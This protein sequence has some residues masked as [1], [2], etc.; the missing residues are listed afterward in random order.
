[1]KQ[2]II[3]SPFEFSVVDEL[4]TELEESEEK[5]DKEDLLQ[6][7]EIKEEDFETFEYDILGIGL[8]TSRC[9]TKTG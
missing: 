4:K 1:M 8:A 5:N 3:G 9:S 2:E 7:D 6:C